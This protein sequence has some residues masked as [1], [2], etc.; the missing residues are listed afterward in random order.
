MSKGAAFAIS[1]AIWGIGFALFVFATR[2]TLATHVDTV[3]LVVSVELVLMLVG[4][5]LAV[6]QVPFMA[7]ALAKGFPRLAGLS[8]IGII[9]WVLGFFLGMGLGP[10]VVYVT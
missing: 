10:A 3:V 4:F 5:V 1:P 7:W 2:N 6:G 8:A 9:L